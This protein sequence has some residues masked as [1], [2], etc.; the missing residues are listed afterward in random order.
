[1]KTVGQSSNLWGRTMTKEEEFE[2]QKRQIFN[3]F[4]INS[5]N[6]INLCYQIYNFAVQN[7]LHNTQVFMNWQDKLNEIS[8][9]YPDI[10]DI[11]DIQNKQQN[12]NVNNDQQNQN[13]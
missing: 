7:N 8:V 5:N 10:K 13:S 4:L 2:N 11:T 6:S 9:L 1:M 3:T 12:D